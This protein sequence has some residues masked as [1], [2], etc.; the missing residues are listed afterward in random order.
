MQGLLGNVQTALI[1]IGGT[2]AII[3]LIVLGLKILFSGESGPRKAISGGGSILI[4][5]IFIGGSAAIVG[6]LM[7]LAKSL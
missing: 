2:A 3:A 6:G 1:A 5:I 7:A 4:G